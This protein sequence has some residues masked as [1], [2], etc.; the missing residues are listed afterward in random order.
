MPGIATS[1]CSSADVGGT[2]AETVAIVPLLMTTCTS[3]AQPL[4][5]SA[6]AKCS[7]AMI[8]K[9]AGQDGGSEL[10]YRHIARQAFVKVGDGS[11]AERF[12]RIWH[13]AR[14]ATLR[15]GTPGVGV[16]EQA[17]VAARAGRIAFAGPRSD[18]PADAD[19]PEC[20]DCEGR[21]ITPGLVDCHTHLVYGGDRAHEFE[22]RLAGASYEEIARAG[23]GIVSTVA[24]KPGPPRGAPGP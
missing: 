3:S 23:G 21:W 1:C 13:N 7:D 2:L 17:V 10:M 12:D 4:G 24:G 5:R 22:L 14:L 18:F 20:I 15:G 19:A 16:I 11:M 9:P 8:D 6:D